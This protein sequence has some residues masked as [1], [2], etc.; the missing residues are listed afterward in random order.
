MMLSLGEVRKWSIK[1]F[2]V[3]LDSLTEPRLREPETLS[4]LF[5]LERNFPISRK[6]HFPSFIYLPSI[7]GSHSPPNDCFLD[8][9]IQ[10]KR[11]YHIISDS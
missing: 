7:M 5:E 6:G 9:L 11:K 3:G 4:A 8:S 1:R 2:P 10:D